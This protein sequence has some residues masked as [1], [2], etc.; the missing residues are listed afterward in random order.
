[1]GKKNSI[2]VSHF[3]ALACALL[4]T[5]VASAQQVNFAQTAQ[6]TN[7]KSTSA[8]VTSTAQTGR[9]ATVS[10]KD[11]NFIMEAAVGGMEEVELGRLATQKGSSDAVKQFG[12][13][14]VDDHS[15]ANAE[16]TELAKSKSLNVPAEL[17]AKHKADVAKFSK[18][19]GA[20]FDKAYSKAMLDDHNKDVAAFEQQSV[21]G[22][23]PDLKAFAAKTLPTLKTHLEMAKALNAKPVTAIKPKSPNR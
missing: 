13:K 8:G 14:M 20:A 17:D 15:A 11:K 10:T 21:S 5:L 9:S 2:S 4:V 7:S 19:S 3:W 1:M 12:Q 23:D 6:T 22:T 16:L 18:L